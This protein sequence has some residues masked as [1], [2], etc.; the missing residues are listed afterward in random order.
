LDDMRLPGG[1]RE[2]LLPVTPLKGGRP[3]NPL[4]P[5]PQ[6][7]PRGKDP[8]SPPLGR[9]K[10]KGEVTEAAGGGRDQRVVESSDERQQ[11]R[12]HDVE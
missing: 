6:R 8:G 12:Y 1:C 3:D 11:E 2:F 5:R 4:P 7:R 10:R 9:K